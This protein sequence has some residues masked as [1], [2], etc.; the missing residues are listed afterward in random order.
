MAR[1]GCED[2]I[3]QLHRP[4]P[5]GMTKREVYALHAMQAV[6]AG[7]WSD[8]SANMSRADISAYAFRMADAM[9]AEGAK[10]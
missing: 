8:P 6:V 10:P 9:L 4:L 1:N 7:I 3:R 5:A 2:D